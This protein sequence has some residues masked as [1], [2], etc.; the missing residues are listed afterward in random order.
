MVHPIRD[1]PVNQSPGVFSKKP[2]GPEIFLLSMH[3]RLSFLQYVFSNIVTMTQNLIVYHLQLGQC[4]TIHI[5]SPLE[6]SL[7][8]SQHIYNG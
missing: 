3:N 7:L 5:Y 6:G 1:K 2:S 4:I 8:I